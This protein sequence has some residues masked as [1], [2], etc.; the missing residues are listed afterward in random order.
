M[1]GLYGCL[2]TGID[3]KLPD[4]LSVHRDLP[5]YSTWQSSLGGRPAIHTLS[6]QDERSRRMYQS[7]PRT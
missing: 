4:M 7:C 2:V 3:R 6:H 1:P 5:Y